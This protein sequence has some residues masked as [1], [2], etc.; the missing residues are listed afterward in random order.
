MQAQKH[1][2]RVEYL[3]QTVRNSNI[4]I[5]GTH[6]YYSD[7]W[8][9]PFE[10]SV[11]R[12]HYGDTYS[13]AAWQPKWPIDQLYIG[14]FVCVGA[15]AVILMGGNNTHR[16]D[17][18]SCYPHPDHIVESYAG[19]GDTII[20]D[21]VWI[22]MRAMLMP[23]IRLGEGAVVAANTVVTKDVEPYAIVGGNP[24]RA[25]RWRF[26][27]DTRSRL[28]ALHVYDWPEHKFA[29]LKDH[30]C[31]SDLNALERAAEAY[32]GNRPS[33]ASTTVQLG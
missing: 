26:D 6:S 32:D 31:A 25:L 33:G 21:G 28:L 19:K 13:L 20:G 18:F 11:I 3:H 29:S 10:E 9:G 2:S 23:G 8:T 27:E 14:D 15:E 1:W 7:A 5:K 17:W 24:G 22:G 16:V 4:H 12:Y 30:L